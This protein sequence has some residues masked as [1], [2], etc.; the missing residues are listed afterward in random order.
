MREARSTGPA[1]PDA[2]LRNGSL[3]AT[4]Q[5]NCLFLTEGSTF[6]TNSW[7]RAL[8]KSLADLDL[9]ASLS[10][11][12]L[13]ALPPSTFSS[14]RREGI[15][16]QRFWKWQRDRQTEKTEM[17]RDRE[18]KRGKNRET[19]RQTSPKAKQTVNNRPRIHS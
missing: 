19:E 12:E 4:C 6:P 7:P 8:W 10:F 2:W 11:T 18:T 15:R 3:G 16:N 5:R 14:M 9:V 1:K 17:Q 13:Q